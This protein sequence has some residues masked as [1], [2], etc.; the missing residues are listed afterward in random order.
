[1]KEGQYDDH[2]DAGGPVVSGD[3]M[4]PPPPRP[5]GQTTVGLGVIEGERARASG[6]VRDRD[7]TTPPSGAERHQFR[8][9]F[10][11]ANTSLVLSE[12]HRLE[13]K[14][15]AV[16]T[17]LRAERTARGAIARVV[18]EDRALSRE[19][20]MRAMQRDSELASSVASLS[21]EMGRV[22][23]AVI[24]IEATLGKAPQAISLGR[25]SQQGDLTPAELH[26]LE[27]GSGLLGVVGRLVANDVRSAQEA[28]RAAGQSA[29]RRTGAIVGVASTCGTIAA[30]TADHWAPALLRIFGG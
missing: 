25:A 14:V 1:M 12:F 19:A 9:E 22:G 21:D 17:D 5:S 15:D 7:Q 29:A 30:A 8:P 10:E 23:A 13:G 6:P 16:I 20:H 26:A 24:R 4:R 2:R 11:Q 28:G 27:Q 18:A 3:P